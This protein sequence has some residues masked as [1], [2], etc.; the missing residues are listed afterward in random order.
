MKII[1]Q[2]DRKFESWV[3]IPNWISPQK[4]TAFEESLLVMCGCVGKPVQFDESVRYDLDLAEE[5]AD[6]LIT[7]VE[8][9]S[10]DLSGLPIQ[11]CIDGEL[12]TAKYLL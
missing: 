1:E 8:R 12:Y 11:Y 5:N 6:E 10:S 3:E 4:F 7:C 9:F 2:P